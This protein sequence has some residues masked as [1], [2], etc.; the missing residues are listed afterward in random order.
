MWILFSLH[1]LDI[2]KVSE[3]TREIRFAV[4]LWKDFLEVSK[5]QNSTIP[6]CNWKIL[7]KLFFVQKR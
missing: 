6:C 1:L 7:K 4:H 3:I 2:K 5:S